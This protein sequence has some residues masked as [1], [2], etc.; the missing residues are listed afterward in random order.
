[1]V[2]SIESCS[3]DKSV[4]WQHLKKCRNPTG[5]RVLA[6]KNKE[7]QVVYE[8]EEILRVWKNHFAALSTP[9]D[10]PLYDREYFARINKEVDGFNIMNDGCA[11]VDTPFNTSE[12]QKAVNKLKKNKA[13]GYDC[14]SAEHVQYG[15]ALLIITINI[16]FNMIMKLEYV[17]INFRR[18]T[19]IPLFKGKNLCST[20]T[21]NYRGITLLS[22]FRKIYELLIWSRL[23]TW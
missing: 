16:V 5:S 9:K 6:I 20:D 4:F 7:K 12:V 23:E 13:C 11:F 1:M 17:P 14:I 19:Q 15:G 10:D 3:A 21:N 22:T 18:G 8:I 2:E